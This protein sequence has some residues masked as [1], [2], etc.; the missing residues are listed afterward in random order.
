MMN[1]STLRTIYIWNV[2]FNPYTKT[3]LVARVQDWLAAGRKGIHLTGANPETV[4]AAQHEATLQ[5][6]IMASDLV[7]VDNMLVLKSL[8]FSGFSVP[9]RA[10]TPDVFEM[11]LQEANRKRQSV[12]LLGATEPVLQKMVENIRRQYPDLVLAG[13]R[14]GFYSD[15]TEVV[16]EIARACPDY[17]FLGLPSPQ[18]ENFIL[19]HKHELNAGVCYGVGGAFDV[20]GERVGRAPGWL[21]ELGLEGFIRILHSP[22]NYGKRIFRFYP[23][24][25]RLCW[26]FRK[27]GRIVES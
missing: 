5:Q 26:K 19:R 11:F 7:N 23:E 4:V 17:L 22:R 2:K 24:F 25:L 18:K 12:Y 9:E 10:A 3:E 20:K 14:N 8:R 27:L 13:C 16:A 21:R 15:E 6:A 1:E